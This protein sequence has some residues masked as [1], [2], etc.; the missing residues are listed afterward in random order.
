MARIKRPEEGDLI[1]LP[2]ENHYLI[3]L[4]S[5]INDDKIPL[6]Y[7]YHHIF[8]ELPKSIED[9]SIDFQKPI[10]IKEFGSQGFRDGTWKILGSMPNFKR[11]NFPVPL[12]FHHTKPF[13]PVLVYFDDSMNEVRRLTIEE[14]EVDNYKDFPQTGLGGSGFIEKR[15]K[16]LITEKATHCS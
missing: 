14:I 7:F 15:L 13:K 3:G 11:D 8:T 16:R 4:V 9:V 1:A 5:R 2:I 12:F 6:G 10:L